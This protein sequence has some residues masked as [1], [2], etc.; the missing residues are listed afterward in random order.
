MGPKREL[1]DLLE[2]VPLFSR[3][4]PRERRTIARHTEIAEL[5]AGTDLVIEG[6]PGDALFIIL[7]GEASIVR[8]DAN[9][10]TATV[11]PGTYF[12]ELAILDGSPR[13]AT[14]RADTDVRVGVLGIRM[15]RTLL[16]EVP[17]L[18]EQLL[19]GLAGQ[20]R[21]AQAAAAEAPTP[22]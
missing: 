13:S 17:D 16:R 1:A 11:G 12:G 19:V 6:E 21:A 3:C 9:E 4:T 20:L 18:A 2:A 5:P 14:V 7:E 10:V 15:F 22:A 8:S